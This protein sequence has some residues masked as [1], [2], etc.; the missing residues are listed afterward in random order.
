MPDPQG[1]PPADRPSTQRTP[2]T[3]RSPFDVPFWLDLLGGLVD[4]HPRF[5]TWL[6]GLETRA[7]GPELDRVSVRMPIY[8]CGLA[9]SGTTLLHEIVAAHPSVATHRIKD[10]PFVFTPYWWRRA[11]ANLRPAHERERA[12]GDR[13]MITSESADA[14]EE[15]VWMAFFPDCHDPST[16]N[17]LGSEARHPAFESFYP[18]LLRKLLLAERASRY[19]AKANYHVARLAYLVRLFPDAR[20]VLPVRSPVGH[21]AS[22]MRQHERFS[23]GQTTHP[24]A[25]AFMQRSGHFE[26]GLDRRPMNLGDTSRVEQTIDDWRSGHEVR[27]LARYWDMVYAYLARLLAADQRVRAATLVVRFEALCES[28]AETLARLFEHVALPDADGIIERYASV[29]RQPDYYASPLTAD[30]EAI[31]HDATAETARLWGY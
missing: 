6:S 31:I 25:L 27:G 18:T 13:I 21:V 14:L 29:I 28:P 30:D 12:H 8:I 5:W 16:T 4:R 19:A 24:R 15:M 17:V 22:L 2:A 23:Q 1:P 26:F 20:F 10:Y 7:I 11:S 3:G 9:R